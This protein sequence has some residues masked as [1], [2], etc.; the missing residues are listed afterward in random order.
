MCDRDR[1]TTT[2]GTVSVP[3]PTGVFL[4]LVARGRAREDACGDARL[5]A[6]DARRGSTYA[7]FASGDYGMIFDPRGWLTIVRGNECARGSGPRDRRPRLDHGG[8][9]DDRRRLSRAASSDT[10]RADMAG[11]RPR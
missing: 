7:D 4:D 11:V 10:S 1:T 2:T 9:G 6:P 5:R 8:G 3:P